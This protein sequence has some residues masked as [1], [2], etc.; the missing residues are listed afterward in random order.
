MAEA[1]VDRRAV[2]VALRLGDD[3]GRVAPVLAVDLAQRLDDAL[4][5]ARRSGEPAGRRWSMKSSKLVSWRRPYWRRNSL[6]RGTPCSRSR[7]MSSAA[8]SILLVGRLQPRHRQVLQELRSVLQRQQRRAAGGPSRA[9]SWPAP[10]VSIACVALARKVSTTGTLASD[11][12][13]VVIPLAVLDQVGHQRV[14]PVD[15]DELL[16][17]VERRAEMI[18]AAVDVVRDSSGSRCQSCFGS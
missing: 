10:C 2:G 11:H 18:D 9:P 1:V 8:T 6:K 3:L 16:G 13:R 12:V 17:E 15:G 7:M 4:L 5:L 14:Q